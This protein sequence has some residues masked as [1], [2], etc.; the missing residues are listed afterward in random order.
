MSPATRRRALVFLLVSLILI[1]LIAAGLPHLTFTPGM[2]LPSFVSGNVALP[3]AEAS[4]VGQPLGAFAGI[5]CLIIL[6]AFVVFLI[7]Q[8]VRGVPWKKVMRELWGLFWKFL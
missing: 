8:A 1:V 4:S 7:V 5:L 3:S 6:A 2:P